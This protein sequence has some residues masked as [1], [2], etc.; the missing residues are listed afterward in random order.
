MTTRILIADDDPVLR[1]LMAATLAHEGF[2]VLQAADGQEAI[3]AF[4]SDEPDLVLIDVDMPRLDGFSVCERIRESVHGRNVP[5][6]IITGHDDTSSI[7]RCFEVGA[8]DF[9]AKPINWSLI[10]HRVRYILRSS[11]NVQSLRHSEAENRALLEAMPDSIYIVDATGAIEQRIGRTGH[12]DSEPSAAVEGRT[13]AAILPTHLSQ[14]VDRCIEKALRLG[15]TQSI[16][17]SVPNNDMTTHFELRLVPRDRERLLFIRRDITERKRDEEKINRLAFYDTLTGLPNRAHF[18]RQ[19]EAALARAEEDC[20]PLAV[21]YIDVD[22]F[23]RIN[24]T[25]GH[26]VGDDVLRAVA[27]R[28]VEAVDELRSASQLETTTIDLARLGGDEFTILAQTTDESDATSIAQLLL[29]VFSKPLNVGSQSFYVTPSIGISMHPRDGR[30]A[31]SIL[32]NSDTAMYEAKSCGRNRYR[33][34]KPTMNSR[35]VEQLVLENDL[36]RALSTEELSL[37]YQPKF[38]ASDTQIVGAEALL[39]WHHPKYGEVS[40]AKLIPLAEESGLIN[41]VSLWIATRVGRQINAWRNQGLSPVPVAINLSAHDFSGSA[42]YRLIKTIED[43]GVDPTDIELEITE[44]EL[45]RD[46]N[47]TKHALDALRRLNFKV[48]LDDFGTAYSSL[49]YIKEFPLDTIKIDR[50]FV[51]RVAD[52]HHDASICATII[53]LGHQLGCSVVA[54]G[55]E[56]LAQLHF[57]KSHGCDQ[58]QGFLLS[59]PLDAA[60]FGKQLQSKLDAVVV[61]FRR[62]ARGAALLR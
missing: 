6:V 18:L 26:T 13:L 55:V 50:S 24:D 61:P 29:G 20:K 5:V 44:G 3:R 35:S 28:L 8:T 42:L 12:N 34:Y 2:G 38:R 17:Y 40:P 46:V 47:E 57:L 7:D 19:V 10:G 43:T 56:D 22:R 41:E 32:K 4:Y 27:A 58:V 33:V 31:V 60:A 37:C 53:E 51:R 45:M 54:E 15:R 1:A 52:N 30:D 39:R 49:N 23:K 62:T 36:R 14:D 59:E 16:E 48:A 9:V 25:L 21:L 11:D